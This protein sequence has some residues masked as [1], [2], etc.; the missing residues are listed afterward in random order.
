MITALAHVCFS[1]RDLQTSLAF[2]RD[3][4]GLTE[5]FPVYDDAGVHAGQY[6]HI[7]GRSFLELFAGEVAGAGDKP[8]YKHFCLEVDDIHAEAN[9]LRQLGVDVTE[10]KTGSDHSLQCWLAD[11]D[12]NRIEFHEYTPDSKQAVALQ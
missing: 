6:L 2:Y 5:T 3:K 7:G 10:V 8:S 4:L 9:R 11:P 1:V 12:D